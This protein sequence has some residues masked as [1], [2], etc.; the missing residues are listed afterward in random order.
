[1]NIIVHI[2]FLT[3]FMLKSKEPN[4]AVWNNRPMLNVYP[5]SIAAVKGT[6]TT[7]VSVHAGHV[8]VSR[9]HKVQYV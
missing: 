7:V 5:R 9:Y 3:F 8:Q 1:M 2:P 4:K 6:S